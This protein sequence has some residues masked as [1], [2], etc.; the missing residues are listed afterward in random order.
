[1]Q[2]RGWRPGTFNP[3][4]FG[5]EPDGGKLLRYEVAP[6]LATFERETDPTVKAFFEQGCPWVLVIA[7]IY[8]LDGR[9]TEREK[10]R[11]SSQFVSRT[12]R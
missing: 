4:V 8:L 12:G 5:V 2:N 3:L 9:G 7:D 11:C 6:N 10:R 1:M